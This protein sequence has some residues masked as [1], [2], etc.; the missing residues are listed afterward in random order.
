[1]LEMMYLVLVTFEVS[2]RF[3]RATVMIYVLAK[4]SALDIM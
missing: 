1:M 4:A 2:M 3:L